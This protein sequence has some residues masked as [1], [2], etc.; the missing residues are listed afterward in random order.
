[1]SSERADEAIGVSVLPGRSGRGLDLANAEMI[2]APIERGTAEP[3]A[4]SEQTSDLG[5]EADGTETCCAN[6]V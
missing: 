2:H 1:M 5:V 4:I 6:Q 3:V